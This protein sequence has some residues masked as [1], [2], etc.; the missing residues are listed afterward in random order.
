MRAL[1]I[2]SEARFF[3]GAEKVLGYY[4][5]GTKG[6][7]IEFAVAAV[8][9]SRVIDL[10]PAG[11]PR[12]PVRDNGNFSVL[13]L[14]QQARAL[15]KFRRQFPFDLVHGWAAR[16]W[17]LS[18]L[19]GGLARRPAIGTLH[20]HPAASFISGSRRRLM[21]WIAAIGL[22]RVVCVSD[23]VR[24]ACA[25]ESYS[26]GNLVVVHNGLP[27]VQFGSRNRATGVCR[28]GFLGVFSERKGMRGLFAILEELSRLT[29]LP[30]ELTV[31]GGPQG[32]PG[33]Q[34]LAELRQQYS[35]AAWWPQVEWCGWV[36]N[37]QSFLSTVDIL[38]VPSN[39]FDPLP[40]VLLEAG[41]MG[42]PA[43]AAKVGGVAEIVGDGRTGWLFDSGD[44]SQAARILA[45]L[46]ADPSALQRAGDE[47]RRRV[48]EEFGLPKMVA[49]YRELYSIV[50]RHGH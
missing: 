7:E 1:I 18:A 46:L 32:T 2:H 31:A 44:W 38:L 9:G 15:L 21:Q 39:D 36:D 16:D 11:I 5:S 40:T 43:V 17:E 37:P 48:A 10:V 14:C 42:V 34:T 29:S 33:E 50:C 35:R 6:S 4:L 45:G 26:A 22:H 27:Q 41:Q 47:A 20:D 3:G 25:G 13:R 30:W 12:V 8:A 28:L 23:A 49:Q 24:A 19:V